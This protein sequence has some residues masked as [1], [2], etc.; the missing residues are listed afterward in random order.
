M[1][2]KRITVICVVIGLAAVCSGSILFPVLQVHEAE[3]AG[4]LDWELSGGQVNGKNFVD[5]SFRCLDVRR[6]VT[7]VSCLINNDGTVSLSVATRGL[8]HFAS[9]E[10][11][12]YRIRIPDLSEG[13][14]AD[15]LPEI[16][17]I[18]LE[19]ENDSLVLWEDEVTVDRLTAQMFAVVTNDKATLDCRIDALLTC[20]GVHGWG[21][22]QMNTDGSNPPGF[23]SR[24]TET[25]AGHKLTVSINGDVVLYEKS[26]ALKELQ[27]YS[28]ILIA[29]IDD[30][31]E[32]TWNYSFGEIE[33]LLHF[34]ASDADAFLGS[35]DSGID[36]KEYGKTASGL[37]RLMDQIDFAPDVFIV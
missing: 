16:K 10:E 14:Q 6:N 19:S 18:V 1:N 32:V 27:K 31:D 30:L 29:L 25:D 34:G 2:K 33:D 4:A 15:T 11:E 28:C 9:H 12:P 22:Q 35:E 5:I 36:L 17:K 8:P 20:F 24:L 37:Q 23:G 3:R 21:A 26:D 7:E 13:Y